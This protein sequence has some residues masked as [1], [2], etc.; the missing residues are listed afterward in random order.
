MS[1][2]AS[3]ALPGTPIPVQTHSSQPS[4]C[5]S[6]HRTLL[7]YFTLS[8]VPCSPDSLRLTGDFFSEPHPRTTSVE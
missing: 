2:Y 4:I 8:C 3:E 5:F 7:K 6:P 1:R